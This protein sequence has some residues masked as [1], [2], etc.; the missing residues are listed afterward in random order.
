MS[1]A[2]FDKLIVT[3]RV[4]I[5][6][7]SP[8]PETQLHISAT[9][10]DGKIYLESGG[11]LLQ[12]SVNSTI[13]SI[14]T[15]GN[16]PLQLQTNLNPSASSGIY[17][18][19]DGSV[20]VGTTSPKFDLDVKGTQ[21]II[22]ATQFYKEGALWKVTGK[23][24]ASNTI[25]A[26]NIQNGSISAAQLATNAVTTDKIDNASI[27]AAKIQNGAIARDKLDPSISFE[28][29]DGAVTTA[30]IQ[31]EAITAEKIRD[32]SI[33]AA[34][35]NFSISPGSSQWQ[36]EDGGPISYSKGNVG[37]GTGTS[38]PQAKLQV[39]N[40]AIMPSAGN[41]ETSGIMFPKDPGGGSSDS[42]W[43]RYY[44]RTGEATTLEIG[45]SNDGDDHIALMASGY[46][47][48]FTKNPQA[49]L[50]VFTTLN[51][52]KLR[53]QAAPTTSAGTAFGSGSIEF[54]SDPQGSGSEWRPGFIQS[55][56]EGGFTGGLAFF[57]N[58]PGKRQEAVEV[59]RISRGKIYGKEFA[60]YSSRELKENI[61]DLS[62][63]EAIEALA[64][65]NP[66]KFNYREDNQKQLKA[67]FIA[68][69]VSELVATADRKGI[70]ALDIVAVLTKVIQQQQ[71]ELS[72]LKERLN[73]LEAIT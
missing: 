57:A 16:C 59:M 43:I 25:T 47:G 3:D 73:A 34:K 6:T 1:D 72:C 70:C 10:K 68:E 42:A 24:I 4:G 54:W 41:S 23:E 17:L 63:Q 45:T 55:T 50:H 49:D 21:G 52:A 31:D 46:V 51:Q 19:Q 14:G 30:K 67:G 2:T 7:E 20:G 39:A 71:E 35:L 32:K 37:I 58:V 65:L 27:T 44:A 64:N 12:V 18:S 40:G 60:S 13:A 48:I 33:T 69:D 66:V 8:E 26:A 22:N 38:I 56:D 61:T 11:S 5:G 29:A 28:P 62:T 15:T 9:N 36:G 53:I